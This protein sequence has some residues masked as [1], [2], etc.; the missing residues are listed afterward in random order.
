MVYML[1]QG[2]VGLWLIA[3]CAKKPEGLGSGVRA[4]GFVAGTGL[5]LIALGFVFIAF[6]LGPALVTLIEARSVP[7]NPA[8]VASPLNSIGHLVLK[9]G[10]LLGLPMYPIWA[11]LVSRSDAS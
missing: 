10:S 8:D 9:V 6:A 5:L 2:G 7:V 11:L 3:V 4:L 1:S